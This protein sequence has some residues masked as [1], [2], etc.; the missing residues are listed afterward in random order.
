MARKPKAVDGFVV[1]RNVRPV[2]DIR[3]NSLNRISTSATPSPQPSTQ[4][5]LGRGS[6]QRPVTTVSRQDID[7]SLNSIDN[8]EEQPKRRRRLFGRNTAVTKSLPRWRKILKW[9]I[10]LL[11]L[12]IILLG[13]YVG[14]KAV[15]NIGSITQGDLL[16]VFQNKPLKAD[17]NGRTNILIYGT[18]GTIDDQ[19][20]EGA[21]LTDTLMV[22]SINQE[23]RDAYMVSLP[24]DL[25]V[26]YD[27]TCWAGNR[28]KINAMYECYT[29][30]RTDQAADEKGSQALQSKISEITGLDMQYYA[31]INWAVVTGVVDA[32]GGVDVDVVGD[33]SCVGYGV[34]EDGIVDYNMDVKY[35]GGV[36]HM[37]GDQALR[38]SRAR[39]AAGG[40]GLARGDFDR[41]L[42][43][44]KVLVAL[45]S[46]A[47]SANTLTNIGKVTSLM[48]ALGQNLRT[49]FETSEIRTLMSLG[50]DISS[51][52][53]KSID[54]VDPEHALIISGN[55]PGAG[56]TQVP[57]AGTY[58]YSD[59][60]A[61]IRKTVSGNELAKEEAN[62]VLLN[63]SGITGYAATQSEK[64][65]ELG[66][67]ISGVENA[68]AGAYQPTEIYQVTEGNAATKAKLENVYGVKVSSGTPPVE[69][70][71]ETDFVI[72]F[73]AAASVQN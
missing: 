26:D 57:A 17:E 6:V 4:T 22:L 38:F 14:I 39:G 46:K 60:I 12:V 58:D 16:G 19:R 28:G 47:A 31:H 71:A 61:F 34:S 25:Y 7:E 33:G 66:L 13:L 40:C 54:L 3:R 69:V 64:L 18:S 5:T 36:Q 42:N 55:I 67:A 44:Q 59:I 72:I 56:S 32:V 23:K 73:G 10:R 53:I 48:D 45:R 11:I 68:P 51:D 62:I 50:N 41:Q 20:H 65:M 15:I 70:A 49:N 43:Q 52:E 2:G 63:G 8:E 29:E 35:D 24:R 27:A 30:G 9:V 21:N 1:R 37:N